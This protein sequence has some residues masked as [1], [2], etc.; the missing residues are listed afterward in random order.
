LTIDYFGGRASYS[1]F[2]LQNSKLPSIDYFGWRRLTI[3]VRHAAHLPNS[4]LLR[5]KFSEVCPN[6][7]LFSL[8]FSEVCPNSDLL[9]LKFSEVC[10]NSDFFGLNIH[11]DYLIIDY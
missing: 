4:D 11:I 2:N 1:K 10:R 8:K 3:P 5:L 9:R 6:S 7:D